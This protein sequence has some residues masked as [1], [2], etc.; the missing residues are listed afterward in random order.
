M[1]PTTKLT[2]IALS[3][4]ILLSGFASAMNA[5]PRR[6]YCKQATERYADKHVGVGTVSGAVRSSTKR[7]KIY[8]QQ[9]DKC[10]RRAGLGSLH[11]NLSEVSV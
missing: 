11:I 6:D 1:R 7:D 10:I 4:A 9:Y 2:A 3:V 5:S 8:K